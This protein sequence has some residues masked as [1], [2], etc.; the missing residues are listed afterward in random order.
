MKKLL[1]LV[2]L[3]KLRRSLQK[4][5]SVD[6]KIFP[7]EGKLT[8]VDTISFDVNS[9][10]ITKDGSEKK[11]LED[12]PLADLLIRDISDFELPEYIKVHLKRELTYVWQIFLL[13]DSALQNISGIGKA[14]FSTI[15]KNVGKFIDHKTKRSFRFNLFIMIPKTGYPQS[16]DQELS[17]V[18]EL[19][20]NRVLEVEKFIQSYFKEEKK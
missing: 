5:V 20:K 18:S 14:A 19:G 15:R 12:I 9:F 11:E 13:S 16:S 2:E 1:S 4:P 3:A 8:C 17:M 6:S 7:L 10:N